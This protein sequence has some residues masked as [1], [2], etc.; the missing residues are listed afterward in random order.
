[1]TQT[2]ARPRLVPKTTLVAGAV[3]LALLLTALGVAHTVSQS[4]LAYVPDIAGLPEDTAIALLEEAGLS[5]RQAGTQVS[6]TVPVGAIISQNPAPETRLEPGST[7]RYVISAGPQAFVVPD[8]IGSPLQGAKDVLSALGFSVVVE[9]VPSVETTEAIVL[10]MFPAPG[11]S[12]SVGDEIRLVVPGESST[13]D[14]LLPYDL[15]GVSVLLD[16]ATAPAGLAAD[17]PME[18]ARRLRALLEAAGAS[19]AVTRGSPSAAPSQEAREASATAS[20]AQ[21]FVGIDVGNRGVAGITVFH[22]P[23]E[24][25]DRGI[26]SL[27]YAR[28]VTRAA[29]LP[30]LVVSEPAPSDD[31][32]LLSFAGAGIRVVLGDAAVPA[33]TARFSDPAWADQVARSIYRGL[34]TTLAP[35]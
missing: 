10:E 35:K 5:A 14:V 34:G 15:A 4:R 16:P 33:D 9:T 7:V 2:S 17:A 12:V 19:V 18:V 28:A 20:P 13:E 21:V 32:V 8:L 3:I 26:V 6:V 25:G 23:T 11:S 1:M 22:L 29:S 31:P 30:D 24:E 27:R